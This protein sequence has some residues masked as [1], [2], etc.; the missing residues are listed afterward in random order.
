MSNSASTSPASPLVTLPIRYTAP[1]SGVVSI[2]YPD[3]LR[4]DVDLS[5]SIAAAFGS[6]GIGLLT[7]SDIPSYPEK[8]DALLPL[9]ARFAH[10]PAAVQQQYEDPASMYSFGWSLGREQLNNKPDTAKGSYYNN[11]LYDDPLSES[12]L[13]GESEEGRRRLKEQ[14]RPFFGENVWPRTELPELEMAF[15]ALGRLIVEVGAQLSR[16]I[17]RYIHEQLPAYPIDHL[18]RVITTSRTAKA[19]L[20]HYFPLQPQD[21]ATAAV[22]AP[23]DDSITID[24]HC[25]WHNDHG[26]LTGLT[27]AQWR[28]DVTGQQL[29]ASPDPT[30]GLYVLRRDGRTVQVSIPPHSLAFQLGECQMIHSGALVQATPHAVRASPLPSLSRQTF[31]VFMEPEPHYS[32]SLPTGVDVQRLLQAKAL[33]NLPS[34]VPR[35]ERRWKGEDDFGQFTTKT[36][37]AYYSGN[38]S[39]QAIVEKSDGM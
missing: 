14:H 11:P 12:P 17:D 15:K 31:A 13:P 19:R 8:R 22:S 25:G 27:S 34:A 7:V 32:M 23:S 35:M 3:L 30:A 20:L 5:A 1:D 9:A 37:S 16:H 21:V 29:P 18:Y 2:S 36:L 6:D 39:G 26:S 4:S 10:L 33:L 38:E 24:S 28:D